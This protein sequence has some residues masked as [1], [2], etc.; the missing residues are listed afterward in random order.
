MAQF[1][2]DEHVPR[3]VH[4]EG[5]PEISRWSNY[6]QH[7]LAASAGCGRSRI[8]FCASIRGLLRQSRE[9]AENACV[10]G[11]DAGQG[12]FFRWLDGNRLCL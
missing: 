10:L 12:R 1:Y 2:A 3:V 6:Q 9:P 7:F 5:V 4:P 8:Y 11:V